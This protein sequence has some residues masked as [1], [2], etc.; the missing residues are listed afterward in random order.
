MKNITK[1][2]KINHTRNKKTNRKRK[3]RKRLTFKQIK[4]GKKSNIPCY[5]ADKKTNN[6]KNSV[7]LKKLCSIKN[8]DIDVRKGDYY[9]IIRMPLK[10]SSLGHPYI[11]IENKRR[12]CVYT[13]GFHAWEYGIPDNILYSN[14]KVFLTHENM[15]K[16]IIK[17]YFKK[18]PSLTINIQDRSAQEVVD[19]YRKKYENINDDMI[20]SRKQKRGY[21]DWGYLSTDHVKFINYIVKMSKPIKRYDYKDTNTYLAVNTNIIYSAWASW[22][23]EFFVPILGIIFTS[24]GVALNP[25]T[26]IASPILVPLLYK[27]LSRVSDKMKSSFNCITGAYAFHKKPGSL[28][29]LVKKNIA[30]LSNKKGRRTKSR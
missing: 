25:L 27:Y 12:G 15:S 3:N 13:F 11:E 5:C 20:I 6:I 23:R 21:D 14:W 19:I 22:P 30:P 29:E 8:K 18:H 28:L 16:D 1:N 4:C 2:K 10:Y 24:I 17:K 9:R 26:L 7:C